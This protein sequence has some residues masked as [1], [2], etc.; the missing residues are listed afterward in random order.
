MI[1]W[2]SLLCWNEHLT[3]FHWTFLSLHC[4]IADFGGVLKRKLFWMLNSEHDWCITTSSDIKRVSE[5]LTDSFLIISTLRINVDEVAIFAS[6]LRNQIHFLGIMMLWET[7]S[8]EGCLDSSNLLDFLDDILELS[9]LS[10]STILTIGHEHNM[11]FSHMWVLK[12]ELPDI[13]ENREEISAS[14]DLE[15]INFLIV[16]P[17]LI[18]REAILDRVVKGY[19]NQLFKRFLL[20]FVKPFSELQTG[21]FKAF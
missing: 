18:R 10:M 6:R 19:C 8:E 20:W 1:G 12:N 21:H 13:L 9:I 4:D 16:L 11:N 3:G 17:L 15:C 5:S 2:V 14:N 7:N